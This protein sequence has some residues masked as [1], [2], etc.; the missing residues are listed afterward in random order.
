MNS[1]THYYHPGIILR[2][3]YLAESGI[4]QTHLAN[5]ID[6]PLHHINQLCSG[7]CDITADIALR[8]GRF[9]DIDPDTFTNLQSHYNLALAAA[10][11]RA[12]K[13]KIR[14]FSP[15]SVTSQAV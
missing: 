4:T 6:I 8:L 10:A 3:Y 2:D 15:K 11:Q 14:P 7:K 5:A 1:T 12:A 13:L 9:F